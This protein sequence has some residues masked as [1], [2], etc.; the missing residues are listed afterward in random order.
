ME[1]GSLKSPTPQTL[2]RWQILEAPNELEN[3]GLE[4]KI[5]SSVFEENNDLLAEMQNV[6]FEEWETSPLGMEPCSEKSILL[7]FSC[8]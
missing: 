4:D 6:T 7:I 5:E 8:K 2:D 3:E 1:A